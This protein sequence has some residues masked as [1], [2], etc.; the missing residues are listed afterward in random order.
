MTQLP[1]ERRYLGAIIPKDVIVLAETAAASERFA[2]V[3]LCCFQNTVS[4]EY[5]MQFAALTFILPDNSIFVSYRGTDDSLI[6]WK[7]DFHM[8]FESPVP[9]QIK[10]VEYLKDVAGRLPGD[11][12]IGGHSKGGNLSIWASVNCD[13]DV[14]KRIRNV[15]C[16]DGPG[17]NIDFYSQKHYSEISD[18]IVKLVPESSAVGIMFEDNGDYEIIR[19]R[20]KNFY[21]HD[22]FSW[23]VKKNSFVRSPERSSFGK[24]T[25]DILK[26]WL[27]SMSIEERRFFTDTV[28]DIIFSTNAKTLTDLNSARM[29]SAA[30]AA[31]TMRNMDKETRKKLLQFLRRFIMP[32]E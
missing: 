9:S 1:D 26:R 29:K 21:Q 30:I 28:F 3:K 15:Y 23:E 12:R 11:I 2:D 31:H 16:N 14:R 7:E 10:A 24:K 8:M 13:G 19:S 20:E 5:Y 27:S 4:E 32:S 22:P 17:F 25:D 6:G 18:R